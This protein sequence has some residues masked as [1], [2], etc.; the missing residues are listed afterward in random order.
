MRTFFFLSVFFLLLSWGLNYQVI[1]LSHEY[2]HQKENYAEALNYRN[3]LFDPDEWLGNEVLQKKLEI[4]ESQ[5]QI[6]ELQRNR[7]IYFLF[8]QLGWIILYLGAVYYFYVKYKRSNLLVLGFIT[9]ALACLPAGL[10]SP[11]LEIGAAERNLSLG[12]IPIKAKVLGMNVQVEIEQQFKGDIYFYYQSK[13]VVEL[14]QLLFRQNNW[15]VGISILLFSVL[16]PLGKIIATYLVAL[17]SKAAHS[18]ALLFFIKNMGKWSMADVFVVAV[19]LAF[20]AFSNMQVGIRTESNVLVGLYFFLSY[21]LLSLGASS[22]M[23]SAK[24]TS[25]S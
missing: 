22:F 24:N 9:A 23:A 25:A 21:C 10:F 11:M 19:F 16:F 8:A 18:K 17:R 15:I 3:R 2:Q 13:S 5:G 12:E 6:L 14:I 20:L 7:S 1:R 4:L